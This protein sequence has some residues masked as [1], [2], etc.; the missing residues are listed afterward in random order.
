MQ[1]QGMKV[2]RIGDTFEMDPVTK[3][4]NELDD[5]EMLNENWHLQIP[6]ESSVKYIV[7]LTNLTSGET[8][9]QTAHCIA[10]RDTQRS[11]HQL[12]FDIYTSTDKLVAIEFD[13]EMRLTLQAHWAVKDKTYSQTI[14][15]GTFT[16]NDTDTCLGGGGWQLFISSRV[17]CSVNAIKVI[18]SDGKT[19]MFVSSVAVS[20][21]LLTNPYDER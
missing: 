16:V 20:A 18:S 2:V 17:F 4:H 3:F 6:D 11:R 8:K 21:P 19:N 15:R 5:E 12:Y 14:V 13:H 9:E 7:T 10:K 1:Q